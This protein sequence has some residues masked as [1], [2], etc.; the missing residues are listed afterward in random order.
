MPVIDR[1]STRRGRMW[2]GRDPNHIR[3]Q[4]GE[5]LQLRKRRC[6]RKSTRCQRQRKGRKEPQAP[7]GR[8]HGRHQDDAE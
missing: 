7:Y 1:A 8:H 3:G 2:G 5:V 4:I 6:I